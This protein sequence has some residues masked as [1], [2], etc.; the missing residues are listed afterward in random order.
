MGYAS[1]PVVDGDD[2]VGVFYS[3]ATADGET[4]DT[5]TVEAAMRPRQFRHVVT[6]DTPYR[7]LIADLQA[8]PLLI[9]FDGRDPIGILTPWDLGAAP[10]RTHFYLLLSGVE[11]AAA[12]WVRRLYEDQTQALALLPETR[13]VKIAELYAT[14][15]TR[16]EQLDQVAALSL[17][18]LVRILRETP[19]ARA[20]VEHGGASFRALKSVDTFRND[21]MHPVRE[22]THATTPGLMRLEQWDDALTCFLAAVT[23]A[24]S[25][26]AGAPPESEAP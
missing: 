4:H 18:D 25:T 3:S 14:L 2:L 15:T 24:L 16:D 23:Q 7:R 6:A 12:E 9:V 13:A 10:G 21:V 22:F 5:W 20:Q 19:A 1:A 11:M 17:H 8:E 26:S